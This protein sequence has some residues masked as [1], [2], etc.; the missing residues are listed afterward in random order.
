MPFSRIFRFSCLFS[1]WLRIAQSFDLGKP[2][3]PQHAGVFD[4]KILVIGELFMLGDG[5]REW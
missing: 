1:I 4:L 5:S 3:P 2:K